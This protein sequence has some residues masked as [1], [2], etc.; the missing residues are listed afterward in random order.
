[1]KAKRLIIGLGNPGKDYEKTRHNVGFRMIQALAKEDGVSF[2]KE[3]RFLGF[4]VKAIQS[5]LR[6]IT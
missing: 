6:H 4:T 2:V 3:N 5:I 1:M